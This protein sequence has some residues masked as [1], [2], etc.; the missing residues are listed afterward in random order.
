MVTKPT[1]W[2]RKVVRKIDP[3]FF[4]ELAGAIAIIDGV[5]RVFQPAALV[6]AGIMAIYSVERIPDNKGKEN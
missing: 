3:L 5:W 1:A 4:V 6:L 2:A